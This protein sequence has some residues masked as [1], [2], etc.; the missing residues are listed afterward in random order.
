MREHSTQQFHILY[1]TR[2][3][4]FFCPI[5]TNLLLILLIIRMIVVQSLDAEISKAREVPMETTNLNAYI[6]TNKK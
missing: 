2:R 5:T 3:G 4:I 6:A 1:Q